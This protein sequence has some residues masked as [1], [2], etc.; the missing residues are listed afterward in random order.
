M[1]GFSVA[2]RRW[3]FVSWGVSTLLLLSTAI[4]RDYAVIF[5][6][7]AVVLSATAL[8]LFVS[9]EKSNES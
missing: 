2:K 9:S 7:I 5:V 6:A 3:A 1:T 4:F 8:W